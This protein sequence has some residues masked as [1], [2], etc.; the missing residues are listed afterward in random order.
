MGSA[1]VGVVGTLLGVLIGSYFQRKQA[2]SDRKSREAELELAYQQQQ[3][4]LERSHRWRKEDL[5]A[6]T[7]RKVYTEYLRAIDASY[8]QAD[9]GLRTR[10][11]DEKLSTAV[12][13]IELLCGLEIRERVRRHSE[14]VLSVHNK[15]ASTQDKTAVRPEVRAAD[16]ERVKVIGL[17]KNDLGI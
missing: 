9:A 13:E 10:T 14:T 11:E 3:Q 12:A 5:L 4:D 15:L 17:F 16:E 2:E 1:V 8:A 6:D 7:K